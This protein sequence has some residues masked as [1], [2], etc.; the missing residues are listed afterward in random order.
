MVNEL[1][2]EDP[3]GKEFSAEIVDIG[4]V[5]GELVLSLDKTLFYPEGGGQPSDRG[6][7]WNNDIS[8]RVVDVEKDDG[9]RHFCEVEEGV[10]DNLSI[11]DVV[12]GRIDWGRRY[13]I[14]KQHSGQHI[15]SSVF[16]DRFG[17]NTSSFSIDE[18]HTRINIGFEGELT[19]DKIKKVERETN[20]LVWSSDPINISW[21]E[22]VPDDVRK[23]PPEVDKIRVVR[24]GDYNATPCGGLHVRKTSEIGLVKVIGFNRSSPGEWKIK[25]L[26]GERA[27]KNYQSELINLEEMRKFLKAEGSEEVLKTLKKLKEE[28]K[29]LNE[30]II[31]LKGDLLRKKM[32]KIENYNLLIEKTDLNFKTAEKISKELLN[33]ENTLVCIISENKALIG[34][35]DID[36]NCNNIL[37]E[38][39]EEHGGR[40]GGHKGFAQGGF[41]EENKEKVLKT[42]KEKINKELNLN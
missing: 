25:F 3:Y 5:D 28:N 32:E 13:E 39:L 20:E 19:W 30:R 15:L 29:E 17:A 41:P 31:D 26:A 1:F 8:L 33:K 10:P 35:K 34:C 18:D 12:S 9:F 21:H 6:K 37:N 14:M 22:E 40:G 36:I 16:L 7:L 11:G 23:K 38:V 2:Y 24:V 4:S 42:F 27:L